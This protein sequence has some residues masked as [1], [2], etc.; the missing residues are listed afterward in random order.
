MKK[1]F[2]ELQKIIHPT[3]ADIAK[4][5]RNEI[6]NLDEGY[7]KLATEISNKGKEWHRNIDIV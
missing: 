6:D 3:Y 5:L 4:E 1:D 2:E 7:E